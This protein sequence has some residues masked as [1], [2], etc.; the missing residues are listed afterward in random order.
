MKITKKP[1]TPADLVKFSLT[2]DV[3]SIRVV[4]DVS[5]TVSAASKDKNGASLETHN[6]SGTNV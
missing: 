4:S 3:T 2:A 5:V 1:V 6:T